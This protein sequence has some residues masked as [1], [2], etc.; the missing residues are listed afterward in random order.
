MNR[1]IRRHGGAGEANSP[2]FRNLPNRYPPYRHRTNNQI[3]QIA[4]H[5]WYRVQ[6]CVALKRMKH[7]YTHGCENVY[8][9]LRMK[10][11]NMGTE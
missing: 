7:L 2:V 3:K 6:H 9:L 10:K 1:L 8:N 4:V 5:P 11:T